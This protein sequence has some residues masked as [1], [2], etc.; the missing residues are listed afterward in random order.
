M[1]RRLTMTMLLLAVAARLF[2]EDKPDPIPPLPM[3]ATVEKDAKLEEQYRDDKLFFEGPTWEPK[4]K[5]L[6]FTAFLK[7]AAQILRLDERGKA[8]V[9][10]DK[11][12]GINGTYLS[13]DGRLLG[14]QEEGH[15]V[16]SLAFGADG[17]KDEKILYEN[18]ELW[19]P[20]D[21]CQTPQGFI[22]FTDPDFKNKKGSS[23]WMV[24]PDGTGKK[25]TSE[26]TLPNGIIASNDGKT[27]YVGDSFMKLWRSYPIKDD[28]TIGAGKIFFNPE[29]ENKA[30]PD[31][32]TIDEK[33]NLYFTGRGGI[34]CVS[35]EGKGLGFIPIPE[36]ASNCT[37]GGEDG[38]TLYITCSKKLYALKLNVK[39]GQIA[40][41]K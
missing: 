36:F 2:A 11:A 18:K 39:G 8:T 32:M 35:P 3:P 12:K 7:S 15:C 31:G 1:L 29:S 17:P 28:G 22:Y 23:V 33:G 26:L 38:K 25:L 13:N 9:W 5:K 20:N 30:D 37:F 34:W 6:Y 27:L 16:V 41:Q 40:T 19:Q 14:A 10:Y 21:V 4:S 24:A